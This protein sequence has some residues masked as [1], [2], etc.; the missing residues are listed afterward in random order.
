[1]GHLVQTSQACGD[2]HLLSYRCMRIGSGPVKP[3]V[4]SGRFIVNAVKAEAVLPLG[5]ATL[6]GTQ[7][8]LAR[9]FLGGAGAAAR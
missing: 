8:G 4:C 2:D 9:Q 7:Q 5:A 3:D 6:V 1:M